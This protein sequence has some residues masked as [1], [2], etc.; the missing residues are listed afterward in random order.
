MNVSSESRLKSLLRFL[1][2]DPQNQALMADAAQAAF[3]AGDFP[4]ASDL[5][6]R[7]E[8]EAPLAPSLRNLAGLIALRSGRFDEAA[9]AFMALLDDA[10]QDP[11]LRFN[12]A[13]CKAMTGA[14]EDV[15]SFLDDDVASSAPQ[16]ATLKV[17]ALH[18]LGRPE[19]ALA[20]GQSV[21]K[22]WPQDTP[23]MA[24][25]SVAAMDAE[26][27]DLAGAYAA[28]AGDAHDALATL[29]MLQLN[30]YRSDEALGLFDRALEVRPDSARAL[31]G[32]GL[33]V[34][35]DGQPK[36]AAQYID[37]CATEFGD[38]LG[39]WVA[40]GWAYFVSGDYPTSRL[41]FETALALDDTFAEI[42]GGLAVLDI[43]EKDIESGRKRTERALRL[44]RTCFSG[45]LAKSLLLA[46]DGN[47][48]AA[49]QLQRLTLNAPIGASGMTIG[50]AMVG[51]A[52]PPRR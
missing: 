28:K 11:A 9:A 30:A 8:V 41:R 48:S 3:D 44:D 51:L 4:T 39:S 21:A 46:H 6:A 13:W 5:I 45:A 40:S 31:L 43:V 22:Q 27:F 14:W 49:E 2:Q 20:W 16:A 17:Q 24:A 29:G 33:V 38:H 52:K 34:L 26:E 1:D 15:I 12:M 19:D 35:N 50:Q 25:L 10:P 23:L 36:L 42:H 7:F 37:Q 47:D 18:H 32:K